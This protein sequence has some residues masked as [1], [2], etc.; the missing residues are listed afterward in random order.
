MLF[1][2]VINLKEVSSSLTI[3]S[4]HEVKMVLE[5]L[6]GNKSFLH[7]MFLLERICLNFIEDGAL[8]ESNWIEIYC[9]FSKIMILQCKKTSVATT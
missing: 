5:C 3:I 7:N 6:Y 8:Y 4:L 2:E 1:T 9:N